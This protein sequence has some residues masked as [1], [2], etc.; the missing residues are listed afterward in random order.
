MKGQKMVKIV[1]IMAFAVLIM[2]VGCNGSAQIPEDSVR[3]DPDSA[4]SVWEQL[5]MLQTDPMA[6]DY[7]GQQ[8]YFNGQD[9]TNAYAE[10]DNAWA[11]MY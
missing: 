9:Y 5:E 7:D 8:F 2:V 1:T 10:Y 4:S 11:Y 6:S 3:L